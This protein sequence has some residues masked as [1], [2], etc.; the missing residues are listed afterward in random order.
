MLGYFSFSVQNKEKRN[1]QFFVMLL[2]KCLQIA[3]ILWIQSTSYMTS[4]H[5]S[6]LILK[7]SSFES[8]KT[9]LL[10]YKLLKNIKMIKKIFFWHFGSKNWSNFQFNVSF[11]GP[12][13]IVL[14]AFSAP[15]FGHH[16]LSETT[17]WKHL[18][19]GALTFFKSL[20]QNQGVMVRWKIL[21][22]QCYQVVN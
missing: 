12:R 2:W 11:T 18:L 3:S 4:Q 6:N 19:N 16:V 17:D 9:S 15:S 1:I 13:E 5:W 7:C 20:H 8:L 21:L 22:F 10:W 14:L